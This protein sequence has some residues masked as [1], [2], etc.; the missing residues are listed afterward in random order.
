MSHVNVQSYKVV[1]TLTSNRFVA[2]VSSTANTVQYP[3]SGQNFVVGI[4]LDAV[5]DTTSAISVAGPGSIAKVH[6]N[7][8]CAS[9]QPVKSDTS[10]R[11]VAFTLSATTTSL[12]LTSCYAG[13][14]VGATVAATATVADVF[15]CP[16]FTR[17]SA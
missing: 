14:L 17:T 13:I 2:M 11:A 7:D 6:F 12:T 8:T 1:S 9:G 4:T 3:E 5:L 10:G 15:F 16:G